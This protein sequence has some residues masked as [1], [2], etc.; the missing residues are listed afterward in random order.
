MSQLRLILASGSPQRRELLTQSG[1]RFEIVEPSE[2]A[3]CGICST[4]GPAGLVT[5][6]AFRKAAD[7]AGQLLN[8]PEFDSA[9]GLI[10]ACDTVA[11]CGGAVLGKPVDETHARSMLERL[12][13]ETHRVYSGLCLW[14]ISLDPSQREAETRVDVTEL[15]MDAISD[16]GL[17]EYLA[18]GLWRGKAGAFGFQDRAG[19]LHIV[20]GSE[21]NVIG[22]PLELLAT[23]LAHWNNETSE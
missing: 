1:Y 2:S 17:E 12:R 19:W 8:K 23:M 11:E 5:D 14:P 7:V 15:K 21:S 4:G 10:I 13:G 6:L 9:P 16:D 22:L 20:S 18:S 3:E